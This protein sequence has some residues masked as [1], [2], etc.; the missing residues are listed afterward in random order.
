MFCGRHLLLARQRR[1]NVAGSDGA[2]EEVARIVAQIR[3]E[4]R[5]VR[6]I[7]RADSGFANDALMA[8]G[9]GD[10]KSTRLNSSH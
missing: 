6:I 9:N 4:W 5:R 8:W 10:R 1:A 7:L 3:Q 2:V